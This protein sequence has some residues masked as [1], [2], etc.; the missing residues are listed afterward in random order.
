MVGVELLALAAADGVGK[1]AVVGA[2]TWGGF[3]V[4]LG[5]VDDPYVVLQAQLSGDV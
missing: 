2:V 5:H 1:G 3:V 4:E